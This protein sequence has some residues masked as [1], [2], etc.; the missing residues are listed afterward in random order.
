MIKIPFIKRNFLTYFIIGAVLLLGNVLLLNMIFDNI[1]PGRFDLTADKV[2]QLSPAVKDILAGLDAPIEI[3]YYV[4]SS[5]KMP[6]QWKNLERDVIDKLNDIKRASKGMLD[7]TVFDPSAEEERETYEAS[8]DVEVSDDPFAPQKPRTT[9][10]KIAQQLF[11]KG[12]IPFGVQSTSRDEMSVKRVYSSLVLSYLDRKED[13]I[14]EV[15][16][17]SFGSLEYEIMSRIYK[18]ISNRRPRIGFYP[19]KPEIP[20]QMRQYYRQAP[21]DMY[22]TA[23]E[24]LK[25]Q[26]YDVTRSNITSEDPVPENIQTM[27]VMVDRPLGERQLYE[28]DKLVNKGVR[29][30]MGGQQFNYQIVAGDKPG[31]FDLRG[32]PSR[33]NIN[34]LTQSYGFEFDGQMFMDRS[35]AYIQVP[36]YQNRNLGGFNVRQQRMEPVSKPVIIKVGQE[37]INSRVSISNKITEIFYLFGG[38]LNVDSD[39]INANGAT[40]RTLFTSSRKSWTAPGFG[41]GP[42]NTNPPPADQMLSRQPLGI[43]VEGPFKSKF[44]EGNVPAWQVDPQAAAPPVQEVERVT[45]ITADAVDNKM[46]VFGSTKLFQSDVLRSVGSHQALLMNSVDALTLGDALIDIR[47]KNIRTRRIRETSTVG[48]ALTKTFVVWFAPLVFVVLGIYLNIR[49]RK[50]LGVLTETNN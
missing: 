41:Y 2:Y 18:L 6:T 39:L 26:G 20:P 23:V 46:I 50:N 14:A 27:I 16:P 48:K 13:V 45:E 25:S 8:K 1:N 32:M 28:I 42:V 47:S 11:E 44:T 10:K 12:V 5:E 38:K 40:I 34:T 30:I 36:V 37:N 35:S 31:Q 24:L 33:L 43:L 21:P 3:T 17:E 4:S 19:G 29:I 9:R 15:R 22:E 7:Y 49:R